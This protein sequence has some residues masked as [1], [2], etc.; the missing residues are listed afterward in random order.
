[1]KNQ[2]NKI[3]KPGYKREGQFLASLDSS[4]YL[5]SLFARCSTGCPW[6]PVKLPIISEIIP[7][8]FICLK[9]IWCLSL[10]G[11]EI[12]WLSCFV[13]ECQPV[14]ICTF[15]N[16]V[17]LLNVKWRERRKLT[18]YGNIDKAK[19]LY[20][21]YQGSGRGDRFTGYVKLYHTTCNYSA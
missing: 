5:P 7:S 19:G 12:K 21:I 10:K 3:L 16:G 11:K 17:W 1:M 4:L 14:A 13:K 18:G 15:V 9:S 6:H 20:E 8:Y 2:A